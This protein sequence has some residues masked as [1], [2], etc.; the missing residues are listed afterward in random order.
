MISQYLKELQYPFLYY[1]VDEEDSNPFQFL[2]SFIAGIEQIIKKGF[3]SGVRE[4]LKQYSRSHIPLQILKIVLN[5]FNKIRSNFLFIFDDYHNVEGNSETHK[6]VDF[7]VKHSQDKIHFIFLSRNEPSLPFVPRLKL[8]DNFFGIKEKDLCFTRTEIHKLLNKGKNHSLQKPEYEL[9]LEYTEGWITGIQIILQYL[10]DKPLTEIISQHRISGKEIFEYFINEVFNQE[11]RNIRKLLI[12]LSIFDEINEEICKEVLGV[13]D[14]QETLR[15]LESHHLFI[16]CVDSVRVYYR[17][18]PLFRDFLSNKISEEK[19]HSLYKKAGKY[20][21]N[22]GDMTCAFLYFIKAESYNE[23]E[24]LLKKRKWGIFRNVPI[25]L[26]QD[27]LEKIPE[28]TILKYPYLLLIK[29]EYLLISEENEKVKKLLLLAKKK[30]DC[31]SDIKGLNQ[32]NVLLTWLLANKR[33]YKEAL[34]LAKS[35]LK[36]S[37]KDFLMKCNILNR[38]GG[39]YFKTGNYEKAQKYLVDALSTI[40]DKGLYEM[41]CSLQDNLAVL[42]C[43]QGDYNDAYKELST[44]YEKYRFHFPFRVGITCMNLILLEIKMGKLTDAQMHS[45]W[46]ISTTKKY[47]IPHLHIRGIALLGLIESYLE[48]K[49]KSEEFFQQALQSSEQHSPDFSSYVYEP[50]FLH[51]LYHKEIEQAEKIFTILRQE[52]NPLNLLPLYGGKLYY[53]KREFAEALN[54]FYQAVNKAKEMKDK[55]YE[56]EALLCLAKTLWEINE[57]EEAKQSLLSSLK[58]VKAKGYNFLLQSE[59]KEFEKFLKTYPEI[60]EYSYLLEGKKIGLRKKEEKI[61]VPDM[62]IYFFGPFRIFINN[63]ELVIHWHSKKVLSLFAYL[64]TRQGKHCIDRLL[65]EFWPEKNPEKSRNI[66]YAALS[67]IRK[68]FKPYFQEDI[69]K[70]LLHTYFLN[71]SLTFYKDTQDFEDNLKQALSFQN[72]GKIVESISKYEYAKK[73][74]QGD[75][76]QNLYDPWI[77]EEIEYYR[78]KYFIVLKNLGALYK[79]RGNLHKASKIYEYYLDKEPYEDEMYF[80]LAEILSKL[81]QKKKLLELE[82]RYVKAMKELSLSPDPLIMNRIREIL[83]FS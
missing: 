13:K 78:S 70:H 42:K 57:K 60:K 65:E 64:C 33:Q 55:F 3:G 73:L 40:R 31:S 12:N 38:I 5:D 63:E 41:E 26:V 4:L 48:H 1:Q 49:K 15:Y 82:K 68:Y 61:L 35:L 36:E 52:K 45:E 51:H 76:L 66:L 6:F 80:D 62:K 11:P 46:L 10:R 72:K 47:Q 30:F 77:E 53:V 54:Y 19:A 27:Y 43:Q 21:L 69:I 14:A 37:K 44:L 16:S 23:V 56:A 83:S 32:T 74:Y 17:Y 75:F 59:Y 34:K 67:Y 7:L 81:K 29:V 28:S 71:P 18:H 39:V 58:I 24:E 79:K 9:L 50:M 2:W 20:F 8:A 25:G 22:L